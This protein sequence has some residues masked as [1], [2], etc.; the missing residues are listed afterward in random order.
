MSCCL[1]FSA[2]HAWTG[3]QQPMTHSIAARRLRNLGRYSKLDTGRYI[4]VAERGQ[5]NSSSYVYFTMYGVNYETMF[6][7]VISLLAVFA[8]V[9][10]LWRRQLSKQSSEEARGSDSRADKSQRSASESP[11]VHLRVEGEVVKNNRHG[12]RLQVLLEDQVPEL[13]GEIRSGS[14]R[15]VEESAVLVRKL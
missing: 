11:D 5:P 7:L 10:L 14:M 12:H 13:K 8:F 9:L 2:R 6:Q 4:N 3:S 1:E 15:R